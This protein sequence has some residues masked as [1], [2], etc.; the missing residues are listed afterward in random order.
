MKNDHIILYFLRHENRYS[1]G[2]AE[3][4]LSHSGLESARHRL[5]KMLNQQTIQNI[6]CSPLLRTCQT[7]YQYAF[8]NCHKIKLEQSL[9]ELVNKSTSHYTALVSKDTEIPQIKINDRMLCLY[10]SQYQYLSKIRCDFEKS[11]SDSN[12]EEA[13]MESLKDLK[14]NLEYFVIMMDNENHYDMN[15]CDDIK[16]MMDQIT[17][18]ILYVDGLIVGKMPMIILPQG[19]AYDVLLSYINE[20]LKILE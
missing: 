17:Q 4:S 7:I 20:S 16:E 12:S 9:Y 19:D 1:H 10:Q 2:L 18:C 15:H 11:Y 13:K 5:P 6:Y 3:C 14:Q 8:N